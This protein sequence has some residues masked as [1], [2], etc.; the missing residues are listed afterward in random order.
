MANFSTYLA[1]ELLDHVLRDSDYIQPTAANL[2]MALFTSGTDLETNV[3]TAEPSGN[4]Y[5]R[6]L[7][8]FDVATGGGVTQNTADV[9]F[10]TCTTATWGEITHA[11]ICNGDTGGEILY[12]AALDSPKT[13][14]VGDTFKFLAGAFIVEHQ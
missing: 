12:W 8:T 4:A 2:Y 9:A 13:I 1:K 14:N 11:A 7:V 5:A 3:Q 6:T 10:P